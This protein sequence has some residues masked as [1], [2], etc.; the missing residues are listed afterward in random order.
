M[1]R[2]V[3]IPIP[4][5]YVRLIAAMKSIFNQI[6]HTLLIFTAPAHHHHW[7]FLAVNPRG[8]AVWAV[9]EA[10]TLIRAGDCVWIF[11]EQL[12]RHPEGSCSD[13]RINTYGNHAPVSHRAIKSWSVFYVRF[14]HPIHPPLALKISGR[15]EENHQIGRVRACG[16]LVCTAIKSAVVVMQEFKI[17][18]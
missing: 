7:F 13:V 17:G 1:E 5:K 3:T 11:I 8:K 9:L 6:P 10:I 16:M 18:E 15:A 4:S 2:N 12:C 14:Q